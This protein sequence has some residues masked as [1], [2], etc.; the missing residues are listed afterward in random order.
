[1]AATDLNEV[2]S[3]IESRLEL[4]LK[5]APPITVVFQNVPYTPTP[6]SSWCQC[7]VTFGDSTYQTLGGT[8]DSTNVVSGVVSMNIFTPK[9]QGPGANFEIGK[10]IRDLYNRIIIS[11]VSFD[12]P[13]GPQVLENS[14][15]EGY[16]QTQIRVTFD[17]YEDL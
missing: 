9:G 3:T 10:R 17:I 11:G 7:L 8:T 5:D 14:E 1:M 15:P 13:I 16:F 12:A 2:R 6:H 4:E